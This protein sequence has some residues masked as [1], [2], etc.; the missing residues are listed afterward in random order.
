MLLW[1]GHTLAGYTTSHPHNSATALDSHP[2]SHDDA[3][4]DN[5]LQPWLDHPHSSLMGDHAHETPHL[6]AWSPAT[7][8]ALTG[9]PFYA[10]QQVL[11]DSP[12]TRIE[13]PPRV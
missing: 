3:V 11:P 9:R 6:T 2:H 4:N 10:Y 1:A 5:G 12:S 8:D 7:Q 13:R